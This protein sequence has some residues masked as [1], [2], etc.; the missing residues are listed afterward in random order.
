MVELENGI[1]IEATKNHLFLTKTG[2]Y[3]RLDELTENDEAINSI[4]NSD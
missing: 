1:K 2:N 3:K 4:I